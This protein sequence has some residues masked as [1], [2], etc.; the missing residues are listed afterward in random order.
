MN[1]KEAKL[2]DIIAY[3]EKSGFKA[4]KTTPKEVW[5]CSPF[6]NERTASFKVDIYKN[7][8]IDFGENIGGT[9][10]DFVMKYNKCS[11]KEA[12]EILS[13]DIFPIHQQPKIKKPIITYSIKKVTELTNKS[14]LEYL[15]D[16]KINLLFA[17]QFCFQVHYSFANEKEYYGIGF[18]NNS[19]GIEVRNTFSIKYGKICLGKKEITT[20]KNNFKTVSMFESWSD[21]LSYLTLKNCIPNENFIILNSTSM[22]KNVIKIIANYSEIKVFLDNDAAGNIATD[23]LIKNIKNKVTDNRIHYKNHKDLNEFLMNRSNVNR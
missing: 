6:R 5:F 16:R 17:K 9:I 22:I 3:L 1:C 20:I 10:I 8:W 11:V 23:F 18:M 12:L 14:L 7:V 13:K 4:M 2:I 21:F 15:K 19:G